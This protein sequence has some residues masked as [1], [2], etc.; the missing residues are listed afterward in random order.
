MDNSDW[1]LF[2]LGVGIANPSTRSYSMYVARDIAM[3][4]IR[5]GWDVSKSVA[6]HLP[7]LGPARVNL[8]WIMV[9]A[10]VTSF[11]AHSMR[12]G[13]LSDYDPVIAG[14]QAEMMGVDP[15]VI[16]PM[17]TKDIRDLS[18]W[19]HRMIGRIL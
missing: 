8:P 6:K 5:F 15:G 10:E 9:A 2:A 18:F 17:V 4:S 14:H 11:T 13:K 3:F 16:T 19:A 1:A 12:G 7:K